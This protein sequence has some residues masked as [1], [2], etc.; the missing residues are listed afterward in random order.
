MLSLQ[1]KPKKTLMLLN[2][3]LTPLLRPL[4]MPPL[5]PRLLL[6]KMVQLLNKKPPLKLHRS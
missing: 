5:L 4:Q 3:L 1:I 6:Q 2:L